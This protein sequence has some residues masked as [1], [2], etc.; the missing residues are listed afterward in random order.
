[1]LLVAVSQDLSRLVVCQLGQYLELEKLDCQKKTVPTMK[2]QL[3]LVIKRHYI[4]LVAAPA[5][6]QSYSPGIEKG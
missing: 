3:S 1:V 2:K 4:A 6:L 5:L